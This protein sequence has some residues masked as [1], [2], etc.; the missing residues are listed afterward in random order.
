MQ[1]SR[2]PICHSR[3]SL[4]ALVQHEAGRELMALV[5]RLDTQTGAAL[6]SYLGLFRAAGRDLANERALRLAKET[7]DI[8]VFPSSGGV[9]AKAGR[10]RDTARLAIALSETVEALWG[11]RLRQ[12]LKNHNYL[13][14]V[15]ESFRMRPVSAHTGEGAA[16]PRSKTGQALKRKKKNKDKILT[17]AGR[18]RRLL[19][20][21][22]GKDYV[23]VG[24]TRL[25]AG[26]HQ[27]GAE[28]GAYGINKQGAPIPRGD[29]PARPFLGVSDADKKTIL[30][31][32][33]KHL[34]KSIQ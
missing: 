12:P 31:I 30:E 24:S 4:E 28:R 15:L 16:A 27:F 6:V 33:Q 5:A 2:C 10:F 22:A 9:P 26:A 7:L 14:K 23:E 29:I 19:S 21:R 18:L 34:Q 3:I 8:G 20:V 32:I 25:Y 17:E 13:K 11:K 1:L